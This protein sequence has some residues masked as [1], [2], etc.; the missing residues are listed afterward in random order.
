[1]LQS[2]IGELERGEVDPDKLMSRRTL[3]KEVGEYTVETRNPF[4]LF[5]KFRFQ[6]MFILFNCLASLKDVHHFRQVAR[7]IA[8]TEPINAL[9]TGS[10]RE[11]I[12]HDITARLLL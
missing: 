7:V 11:R 1:M 2:R 4:V 3:A 10:V 9:R 5:L 6:S 12:R 8:E